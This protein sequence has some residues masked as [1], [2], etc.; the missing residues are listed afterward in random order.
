MHQFSPEESH[1]VWKEARIMR[2]AARLLKTII[3]IMIL[4][5]MYPF[6]RL[7]Q[8]DRIPVLAY[9]SVDD[10]LMC[11][12]S[13]SVGKFRRQIEYLRSKGYKSLSLHELIS[14]V[15]GRIE[16]TPLKAIVLSFDDG[17]TDFC[18]HALPILRQHGF[19]A[20]LSVVGDFCNKGVTDWINNG[21][22]VP[23]LSWDDIQRICAEGIEIASHGMTHVELTS[24][25]LEQAN[26]EIRK[27]KEQ[28]ESAINTDVDFF[29]YP[30]GACN[31]QIAGLV[32]RNGYRAALTT[33][34]G[35]VREG[36]D[37]YALRRIT[38]KQEL[39]L[40]EFKAMLTPA[41][42]WYSSL[43]WG[44]IGQAVGLGRVDI[45]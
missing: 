33:S 25:P 12:Y 18:S 22:P 6:A 8:R 23:A 11:P 7:C 19:R 9:H 41:V 13:L 17:Y 4:L 21:S 1:A 27:S 36:D 20:V 32:G 3:R 14:H 2:G 39:S 43:L 44:K 29:F 40:L 24:I 37:I 34:P 26:W 10:N 30:H 45:F 15:Q 28:I 35:L 31:G 42:E 5:A 38:M 16:K